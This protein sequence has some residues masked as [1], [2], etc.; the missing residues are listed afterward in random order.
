[1][2]LLQAPSLPYLHSGR[3]I[4]AL[5]YELLC[6][7]PLFRWVEVTHGC[8]HRGICFG[9]RATAWLS[10]AKRRQGKSSSYSV[11]RHTK[12]TISMASVVIRGLQ[13]SWQRCG[14]CGLSGLSCAAT[15]LARHTWEEHQIYTRTEKERPP[16][17]C[18]CDQDPHPWQ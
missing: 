12:M 9:W 5:R 2:P 10:C 13:C 16:D 4:S 3:L 11:I 6:M 8:Y 1:M 15:L 18:Q 14:L 17:C 7:W